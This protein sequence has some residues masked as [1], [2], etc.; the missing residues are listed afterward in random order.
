MSPADPLQHLVVG[1]PKIA[2]QMN[3][4][5]ETAIFRGFG[6]L[7][8][9]NLLYLQAEIA[10]LEKKLR[11]C[12]I[13]DSRNAAGE[14]SNYAV[15]WYWLSQSKADGD[16][17]QLDLVLRIRK[18]LKKYNA[19]L[20]QQSTI[21]QLSGPGKWDL[22]DLQSFLAE[23]AMLRNGA[24]ALVDEE[25][26]HT[27][28]SVGAPK[29]YNPDLI[30]LCPRL[31]EDPVSG[32][33]ARNTISKFVRYGCARFK[34]PSLVHG[35]VGYKD[36]TIFKITYWMTSIIASLIPII[37]IVVLYRIHSTAIRL[38]FIGVFNILMSICLSA[39]TNAKRS[40]I[41]TITTA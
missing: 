33:V 16:T 12:E 24:V 21:L 26:A 13:A 18:L 17:K 25:D 22:A 5:P 41:F 30:A 3:I 32:W 10:Y 9:K 6:E 28:G 27:W 29:S 1:Y 31:K 19:A 38:V 11:D 23:P 15:S 2:G 36:T 37:S 20:I 35:V 40:E 14:K 34:K 8:A 7:N 39:M 4:Q